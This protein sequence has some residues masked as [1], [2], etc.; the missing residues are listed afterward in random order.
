MYEILF[1]PAFW[2]P[3]ALA[4][5]GVAVFLYGNAR[6]RAGV[7][8]AGLA[9]VA[10]TLA[11]C[12]AA[13]AIQT[14]V[15]QCVGRTEALVAAAEDGRWDA[16]AKLIDN[17]TVID[18]VNIRGRANVTSAVQ[19]NSESYGLKAA[20]IL[21]TDVTTGVGTYDVTINTLLEGVQSTTARFT[22]QYEQRSDG[23]LLA[24]LVPLSVGTLAV[25]DMTKYIRQRAGAMIGR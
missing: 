1:H 5:V 18:R 2:M 19:N 24:R 10:L 25:D 12:V 6:V 22:F 13:Y 9:V 23:I 21:S 11:W 8:N 15:E 7:R 14:P 20:H 4:I 3:L 16:F 17:N